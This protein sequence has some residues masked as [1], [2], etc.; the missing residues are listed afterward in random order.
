MN[1]GIDYPW[2]G[3]ISFELSME[4]FT[5]HGYLKCKITFYMDSVQ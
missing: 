4:Q 1:N 2:I 5:I 3:E